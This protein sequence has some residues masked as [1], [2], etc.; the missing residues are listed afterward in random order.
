MHMLSAYKYKQIDT[1]LPTYRN[2]IFLTSRLVHYRVTPQVPT[3][4]KDFVGDFLVVRIT[5]V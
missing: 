1:K 5:L 2:L 3:R 4:V